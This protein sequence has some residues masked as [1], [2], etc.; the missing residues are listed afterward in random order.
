MSVTM[1][2]IAHETGIGRATLY[3]YFPDVET[4]LRSQHE[5][6]VLDH[7][8]QL[9]QASQ[10]AV[11]TRGRLEAVSLMYAR[12]CHHRAQHGVFDLS[13]L[14]HKPEHVAAAEG[15]LHALFEDVL[16]DAA[17]S[18]DVRADIKPGELAVYLLHA[19][20][21]ASNLASEAAVRRLITVTL[22]ALR[23]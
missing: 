11:G 3:K 16:S 10:R 8:A 12:M 21:A 23:A 22:A 20:G 14:V 18:G 4:I 5:R 9:T 19:L 17:R 15:K 6:L 2:R 7:L 1:S 13:V